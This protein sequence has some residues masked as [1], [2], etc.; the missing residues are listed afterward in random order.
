MSALRLKFRINLLDDGTVVTDD[1]EYLGTWDTDES[2]AFF[3]FFPDGATEHL[4]LDPFR[5]ELCNRIEAW[6][7]NL[8]HDG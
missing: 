6:H 3:R 1:G 5:C 4:L 7:T 8:R 2:D